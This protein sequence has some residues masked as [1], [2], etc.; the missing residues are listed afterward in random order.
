MTRDDIDAYLDFFEDF[1]EPTS[2]FPNRERTNRG[3][4]TI[5]VSD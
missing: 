1:V 5:S 2:V 3:S 4:V